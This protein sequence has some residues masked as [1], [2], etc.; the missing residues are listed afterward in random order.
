MSPV[1][2]EVCVTLLLLLSVPVHVAGAPPISQVPSPPKNLV[3]TDE[4]LP[5]GVPL[6]DDTTNIP[7]IISSY[8][9]SPS[10]TTLVLDHTLALPTPPPL[11]KTHASSEASDPTALLPP[12]SSK[13]HVVT[14]TSEPTNLLPSPSSSILDGLHL[15]THTIDTPKDL[16]R[17]NMVSSD[18]YGL[19]P[20]VPPEE[21]YDPDLI[22]P[23]P[24]RPPLPTIVEPPRTSISNLTDPSD[25]QGEGS[26]HEKDDTVFPWRW[27]RTHFRQAGRTIRKKTREQ[28][29]KW[30][31]RNKDGSSGFTDY[32][33]RKKAP[34][35]SWA[36]G[37][38]VSMAM[39]AVL[40]G[41]LGIIGAS[42]AG[43]ATGGMVQNEMRQRYQD[44]LSGIKHER[45][46][47]AK[48]LK[49][50]IRNHA[51]DAI[52]PA[53]GG[54]FGGAVGGLIGSAV[55]SGVGKVVKSAEAKM[56]QN[57]MKTVVSKGALKAVSGTAGFFTSQAVQGV[58]QVG[59]NAVT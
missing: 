12:S 52:L 15:P 25:G 14:E 28:W 33:H 47:S 20:D 43:G 18:Q 6:A 48:A 49:Q 55:G 17:E 41:P 46:K 2:V 7:D 10:L 57:G 19:L 53:V 59:V 23:R 21:V 36:T 5:G 22:P 1:L 54:A 56:V 27:D 44:H 45:P 32:L 35:A 4:L 8:T 9:S 11:S 51:H 24:H 31:T 30:R 3:S 38:G 37:F 42:M 16:G 13:S 26:P 58:V 39:G 40:G 50:S 29:K 34:L